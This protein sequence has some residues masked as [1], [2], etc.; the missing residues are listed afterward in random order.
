M[1][2]NTR[3]CPV[4]FEKLT[5]D[6]ALSWIECPHSVCRDCFFK[7]SIVYE[8]ENMSLK[9]ECPICRVDINKF[10][11]GSELLT[12]D[13]WTRI[14]RTVRRKKCKKCGEKDYP[15]P[16]VKDVESCQI[17]QEMC[18]KCGTEVE[19]HPPGCFFLKCIICQKEE[20]TPNFVGCFMCGT[21]PGHITEKKVR[22]LN[23]NE[24]LDRK[25][26]NACGKCYKLRT[27]CTEHWTFIETVPLCECV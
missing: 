12:V 27:V 3:E 21:C 22:E 15:V 23:L 16:V 14:F 13:L 26:V 10:T 20:K 5:L 6:N 1:N 4:C 9:I 17:H 7:S 2:E 11:G 18:I 8:A 25:L 19:C 24:R